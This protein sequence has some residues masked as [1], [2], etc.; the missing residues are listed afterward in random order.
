MSKFALDK[1]RMLFEGY[2]RKDGSMKK[3]CIRWRDVSCTS[4]NMATI[5]PSSQMAVL[6]YLQ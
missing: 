1:N 2:L 4:T 6:R 5:P 3:L